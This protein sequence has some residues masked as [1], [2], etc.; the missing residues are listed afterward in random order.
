M[1]LAKRVVR[2]TLQ[3]S[4]DAYTP[5]V[6]CKLAVERWRWDLRSQVSFG[7]VGAGS[8]TSRQGGVNASK[9]TEASSDLFPSGSKHEV[10]PDG[11]RRG[12]G[13]AQSG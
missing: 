11:F 13:L 1:Q 4:V 10:R 3:N 6:R 12:R 5:R 9:P 8:R 7:G 2:G